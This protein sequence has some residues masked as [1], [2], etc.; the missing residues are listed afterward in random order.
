MKTVW[1]L[2]ATIL[3]VANSLENDDVA[4]EL[5]EA[6]DLLEE[7]QEKV[8]SLENQAAAV[9]LLTWSHVFNDAPKKKPTSKQRS[10]QL[11]ERERLVQFTLNSLCVAVNKANIQY[12]DMAERLGVLPQNISHILG[13]HTH[14]RMR[15]ISDLAWACGYRA[16]VSFEPLPQQENKK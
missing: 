2:K 7:L 14:L 9:K 13:G 15:T 1:Q 11:Y 10:E 8:F 5:Q 12:S 3:K 4:A 16:V 6:A